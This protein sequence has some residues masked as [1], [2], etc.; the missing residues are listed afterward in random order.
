MESLQRALSEILRIAAGCSNKVFELSQMTRPVRCPMMVPVAGGIACRPKSEFGVSAAP[1]VCGHVPEHRNLPSCAALLPASGAPS[2][3]VDARGCHA[4]DPLRLY[5]A[6]SVK[7]SIPRNGKIAQAKII[8]GTPS[9]MMGRLTTRQ[10]NIREAIHRRDLR[11]SCRRRSS[12]R[13]SEWPRGF[14]RASKEAK[15]RRSS[16]DSG[17]ES[18]G[19]VAP[20][21]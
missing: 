10:R 15:A 7:R 5:P 18:F 17:T 11:C 20:A 16:F 2:S 4:A 19:C 9:K 1:R 6:V 8:E 12:S 3:Y 21:K 13:P 14:P